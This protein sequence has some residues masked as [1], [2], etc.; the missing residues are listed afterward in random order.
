MNPIYTA[1][2]IEPR[3][4]PALEI[5]VSNMLE[6]LVSREWKFI[7]FHGIKNLEMIQSLLDTN[8]IWKQNRNRIELISLNVENL[9]ISDYNNLLKTNRWFYQQIPTDMFLLFQTDSIICSKN[10]NILE[11]FL[12]ERYDYVGAPWKNSW[13]EKRSVGNGG[14][15]LRRKSKMLEIMDRCFPRNENEDE[16]F[17]QACPIMKDIYL[18][19]KEKA[20]T[21]S[22]ETIYSETS[23]A[24]H[25]AWA[26][27]TP[28]KLSKLAD[29][30]PE[31]TL[32]Y[33]TNKLF[34]KTM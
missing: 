25:K 14:F 29:Q 8:P 23:L 11:E 5:V 2:I 9:S 3:N 12:H 6:N 31:Y 17:S 28:E 33:E 15:S 26:Y 34:E 21:F 4:H 16:Y 10:R 1:L 22:I 24:V 13:N 20:K 7:I 32:L 18:P 19:T 30:C 27:L